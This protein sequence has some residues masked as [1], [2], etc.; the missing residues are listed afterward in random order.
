MG[1]LI[2]RDPLDSFFYEDARK[3]CWVPETVPLDK[4]GKQEGWVM[5]EAQAF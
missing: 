5:I 2:E 1:G 4:N 3:K